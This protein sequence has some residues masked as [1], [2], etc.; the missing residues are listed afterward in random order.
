MLSP[1]G[2]HWVLSAVAITPFCQTAL[3]KRSS[4]V[5]SFCDVPACCAGLIRPLL[6]TEVPAIGSLVPLDVMV[7]SG[8][9]M[10]MNTPMA[11]IASGDS[12]YTKYWVVVALR[13][14]TGWT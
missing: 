10:K 14:C 8:V 7:V 2:V 5:A 9:P 3:M 4:S 6:P 11:F 12:L 13:D 1:A